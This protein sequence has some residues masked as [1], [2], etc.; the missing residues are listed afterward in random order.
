[1]PLSTL[2][3][4][5]ATVLS[6][7]TGTGHPAIVFMKEP[8][9]LASSLMPALLSLSTLPAFSLSQILLAFYASAPCSLLLPGTT[10][11]CLHCPVE[12]LALP[13]CPRWH[14][15]MHVWVGRPCVFASSPDLL[16]LPTLAALAA[17]AALMRLKPNA[18]L[19]LP[20]RV[21]P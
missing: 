9:L 21:A 14:Y 19:P 1:M 12:L 8:S 15:P 4:F 6:V 2:P 5:V 10:F 17:T 18:E 16:I 3:V 20:F 13:C 7:P 11:P